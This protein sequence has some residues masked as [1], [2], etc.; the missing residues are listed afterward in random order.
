[1]KVIDCHDAKSAFTIGIV[2]SRF[3]QPISKSLLEGALGRLKEGGFSEN[4]VTV[5]WVPGAIEIPI[6]AQRLAQQGI[7]EAVICLGAVIKGETDH[8]QY[9]C[10]QVSAG[11]QHVA[12]QNDIPI[13]F[14][15]LTTQN[16]AQAKERSGG[17]DGNKGREAAQTAIEMVVALRQI[18]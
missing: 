12:L 13:A 7:Y 17:K 9:V 8:Y 1:M 3:N 18:G 2:V 11:C 10:E 6:T 14:G 16:E 15:V 4:Q 5:V